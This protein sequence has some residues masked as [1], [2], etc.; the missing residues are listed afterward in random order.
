MLRY[1]ELAA[2]G[3]PLYRLPGRLNCFEVVQSDSGR[4]TLP[5]VLLLSMTYWVVSRGSE[6]A[7][8]LFTVHDLTDIIRRN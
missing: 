2:S 1:R 4:P 5:T 3:L 7:G 8:G 6:W